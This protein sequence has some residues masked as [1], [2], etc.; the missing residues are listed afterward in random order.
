[1]RLFPVVSRWADSVYE[2]FGVTMDST[3]ANAIKNFFERRNL[4]RTFE[5]LEAAR[6]ML[7]KTGLMP[8]SCLDL[9]NLRTICI[10]KISSDD[11]DSIRIALRGTLDA[12]R[13]L[14]ARKN[15]SAV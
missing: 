14:M 3:V 5:S 10:E 8:E 15:I 12:V 6:R 7:V 2:R 11:H 1:M 13:A 4:P 9:E